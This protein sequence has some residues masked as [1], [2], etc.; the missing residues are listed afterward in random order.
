MVFRARAR[1]PK[2]DPGSLANGRI[3]LSATLLDDQ[4]HIVCGFLR[5]GERLAYGKHGSLANRR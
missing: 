2:G 3:A 1:T 5:N 4:Q